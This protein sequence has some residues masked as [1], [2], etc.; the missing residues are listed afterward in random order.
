M[1]VNTNYT[2]NPQNIS[3]VALA[4]TTAETVVAAVGDRSYTLVGFWFANP[5][6][7]SVNC[8]LYV[9]DGTN[10]LLIWHQAVAAN[11]STVEDRIVFRIQSGHSIKAKGA[12]SV[13]ACVLLGQTL[14]VG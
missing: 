2:A 13:V 5:T 8:E 11:D 6:G 12:A 14:Q 4:G 3:R 10:D 9:N 1:S 7:S